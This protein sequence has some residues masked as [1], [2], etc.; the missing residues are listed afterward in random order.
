MAFSTPF[1]SP[2]NALVMTAGNYKFM[3]FF[4]VGLPLTLIMSV[5]MVIVIPY[6]FSV[7]KIKRRKEF[8]GWSGYTMDIMANIEK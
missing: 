3:D 8:I 4:K 7:L 1:S 5:V 6:S 2:T